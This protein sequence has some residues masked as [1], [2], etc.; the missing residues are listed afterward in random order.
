[1]TAPVRKPLQV[2]LHRYTACFRR[3]ITRMHP[4]CA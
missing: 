2:T 1:L 4:H 3:N